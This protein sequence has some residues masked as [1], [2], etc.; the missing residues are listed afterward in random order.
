[1]V[2][3]ATPARVELQYPVDD[4]SLQTTL[5]G[6]G[7]G[8]LSSSPAGINCPGVCSASYPVGIMVTL[9]PMPVSGSVFGGWSGDCSG[10]GACTVTM[11]QMRSVTAT[12]D[13]EPVTLNV[14]LD[15]PG[16][17]AGNVSSNP[18]GIDCPGDCQQEY[19]PGTSVTLTATPEPGSALNTW[20][21]IC[22]ATIG[23]VCTATLNMSGGTTVQFVLVENDPVLSVSLTG[24]GSI[25]DNTGAINCPGTCSASY[26]SNT[27]ITLTATPDAGATFQNF[28]GA[29]SGQGCTL[30]LTDDQ[31]V[32]GI[33]LQASEVFIDSFE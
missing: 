6:S 26:P 11:D 28:T 31:Q 16:G 21:G 7:S 24:A 2:I 15:T 32:G 18:A 9:T 8:S 27:S 30:Q 29:C 25:T 4:F 3:S 13:P 22:S 33:F 10:M 17:A 12:F 23:P 1:M 20:G 5:A 14:L 19:P